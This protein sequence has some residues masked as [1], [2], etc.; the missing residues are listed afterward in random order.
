MA[1][2]RIVEAR[3]R[4]ALAQPCLRIAEGVEDGP[5]GVHCRPMRWNCICAAPLAE[6][7]HLRAD[8]AQR[9]RA[10]AAALVRR[11]AAEHRVAVV[12]IEAWRRTTRRDRRAIEAAR[13]VATGIQSG[14]AARSAGACGGQRRSDHESAE[15]PHRGCDDHREDRKQTAI[16]ERS[17]IHD[18]YAQRYHRADRTSQAGPPP[19]THGTVCPRR[20]KLVSRPSR[21]SR[22]NELPQNPHGC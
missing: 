2:A 14:I 22:T 5:V 8:A 4:R 15:R 9:G 12:Q 7:R 3:A 17:R 19:F 16:L 10:S 11:S 18:F 1:P 6:P 20:T 13:Y 21:A